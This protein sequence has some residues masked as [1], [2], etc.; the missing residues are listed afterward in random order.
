MRE[1]SSS[2]QT[3][4]GSDIELE[5]VTDP[6]RRP[7]PEEKLESNKLNTRHYLGS[8]FGI[9]RELFGR[10]DK[11]SKIVGYTRLE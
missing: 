8:N 1:I 9:A 7:G 10:L 2:F 3:E 11:A 5:R 6:A 4:L